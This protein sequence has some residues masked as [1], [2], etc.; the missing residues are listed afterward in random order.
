[1]FVPLAGETAE[2]WALDIT[3][4]PKVDKVELTR[5]D[6][7]QPAASG[8]TSA[9]GP[10]VVTIHIDQEVLTIVSP[11][12]PLVLSKVRVTEKAFYRVEAEIYE[13]PPATRRGDDK[14]RPGNA[15][16]PGGLVARDAQR[17]RRGERQP[18]HGIIW[19]RQGTSQSDS[20]WFLALH[21]DSP[22]LTFIDGGEANLTFGSIPTLRRK[23]APPIL[24][25]DNNI[26]CTGGC[27]D[28]LPAIK[29]RCPGGCAR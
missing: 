20:I 19:Y 28:G 15:N 26:V 1:V 25:D 29:G 18:M 17:S 8:A 3:L 12:E 10:A 5:S 7:C 24:R 22:T 21:E 23:T 2:P 27:A 6:V 14:E 16:N 13:K 4:L 9:A 11:P